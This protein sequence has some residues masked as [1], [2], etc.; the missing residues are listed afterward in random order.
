M[1]YGFVQ[2]LNQYN[3]TLLDCRH[4]YVQ[5]A[6]RIVQE[7]AHLLGKNASSFVSDMGNLHRGLAIK[8]LIS[9]ANLDRIWTTEE[10]AMAAVLIK[11]IWQKQLSGNSL[12]EA[13]RRFE[14]Q[15]PAIEWK[16]LVAPFVR[17]EPLRSE[18]PELETIVI[19]MGNLIAKAD[20]R[21]TSAELDELKSIQS[22]IFDALG[23]GGSMN[24]PDSPHQVDD[25]PTYQR[26]KGTVAMAEQ[27]IP[28]AVEAINHNLPTIPQYEPNAPPKASVEEVMEEL[29]KLVGMEE[30]KDEVLTL[31]NFLKMQQLRLKANL[32][33]TKISLHMVFTGNPGTGKTT[34][35]RILG[36]VFGALGVLKK[37]H[38][39]ET[40][41]SGLVAEYAGQT[42]PKTNR[43]IDQALDG[44]LF[45]DEA[46]SLVAEKG[47]DPFGAEA[48]QALIKRMEDNRDRVVVILAGYPVELDRMI[49]SNPG[50]SSRFN[51]HVN[52]NDYTPG[53]LA[54]IF[55][56]F[57]Q[58]HRYQ[59]DGETFARLVVGLDALHQKRDRFFG[60][61]RLVRNLFECAIRRLAN[62][63]V[64]QTQITEEL[65]T[66]F[67]PSDL[68]FTDV[69]QDLMIDDLLTSH[70]YSICCENCKKPSRDGYR[71]LGKRVKCIQCQHI[72]RIDKPELTRSAATEA[73][74]DEIET[75]N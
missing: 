8:M 42:G 63:V 31:V 40:D 21:P 27:S 28:S 53:E 19:R 1:Q 33:E 56:R 2:L 22:Q 38:L 52:F 73:D 4:L 12:R 45:I 11:H 47:D 65:L 72:F 36:K 68:L 39:V 16:T 10:E 5:S 58:Q 6:E 51:R 64:D 43:L 30:V 9:I 55:N 59:I 41:R 69:P 70:R 49:K 24:Q 48:L 20:G 26:T 50:L 54:Q 66:R 7:Q 29:T 15:A 18:I 25:V 32:P 46:Y 35:A 61:G 14:L 44:I 17:I 67:H 71:H 3:E 75:E 34:V 74:L 37:G 23:S 60:N 13:I 57:C 62:R